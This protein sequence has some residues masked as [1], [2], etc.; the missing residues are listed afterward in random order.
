MRFALAL[1]LI[2]L[3][4][5]E[6]DAA[7]VPEVDQQRIVEELQ[8]RSFRQFEPHVDGDPRK[9]VILDFFDGVTL[10][11]Q[12]AEGGYAVNEW[13]IHAASYSVEGSGSE[14]TIRFNEPESSQEFPPRARTAF[15]PRGYPSPSETCLTKRGFPS[16]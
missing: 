16:S 7:P 4:G 10:W 6:E 14:Y 11:A 3:A 15:Q 5:C 1:S 13:Q 8:D 2:A 12:Y 9:G